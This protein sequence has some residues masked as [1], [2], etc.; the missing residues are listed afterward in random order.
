MRAT[1]LLGRT[2]KEVSRGVRWESS[3]GILFETTAVVVTSFQVCC[4]RCSYV[5]F[6]IQKC[7]SCCCGFC[8]RSWHGQCLWHGTTDGVAQ[9]ASS[10][11]QHFRTREMFVPHMAQIDSCFHWDALCAVPLFFCLALPAFC[12]SALTFVALPLWL[13]RRC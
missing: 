3:E 11:L 9:D 2:F 6:D 1:G 10:E 13:M 8:G 7:C 4:K 12:S 5:P